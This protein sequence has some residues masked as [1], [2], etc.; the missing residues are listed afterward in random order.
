M[1]IICDLCNK[2]MSIHFLHLQEQDV[3]PYPQWILIDIDIS[4]H[5]GIFCNQQGDT[6]TSWSCN[7]HVISGVELEDLRLL[8]CFYDGDGMMTMRGRKKRSISV[9]CHT[10]TDE[11]MRYITVSIFVEGC[12][13]RMKTW[14]F[15]EMPWNDP[16]RVVLLKAHACPPT[17][18]IAMWLNVAL[19]AGPRPKLDLSDQLR[20]CSVASTST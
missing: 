4:I 1:Q 17:N 3:Y 10:H 14:E 2:S 20:R 18:E 15:A 6:S 11:W 7:L 13:K 12:L 19:L 16:V 9:Q 8:R 5:H